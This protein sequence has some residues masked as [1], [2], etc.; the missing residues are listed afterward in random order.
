MDFF[1]RQNT[2]DRARE[3]FAEAQKL[4]AAQEDLEAVRLMNGCVK[5]LCAVAGDS[6]T[7][8][9]IAGYL[10]TDIGTYEEFHEELNAVVVRDA[11]MHAVQLANKPKKAQAYLDVIEA[12]YRMMADED[13]SFGEF[14]EE[15]GIDRR[16]IEDITARVNGAPTPRP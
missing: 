2:I 9:E 15:S 8:E 13:M 3:I 12:T 14:C 4:H 7:G 16:M 6:L 5:M 1:F 11:F 10:D